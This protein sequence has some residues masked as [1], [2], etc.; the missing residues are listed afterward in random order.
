MPTPIASNQ[1]D[2]WYVPQGSAYPR[3]DNSPAMSQEH[4]RQEPLPDIPP[5]SAFSP[6]RKKW[7]TPQG[8]EFDA[9]DYA[10]LP[11]DVNTFSPNELMENSPQFPSTRLGTMGAA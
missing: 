3:T 11:P 1:G 9:G 10:P 8:I 5:G 2:D 4:L 7:R 6:S